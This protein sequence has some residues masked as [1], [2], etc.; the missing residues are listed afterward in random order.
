MNAVD[1]SLWKSLPGPQDITRVEL[2]NGIVILTR[3]NFNTPSVVLS[4]YLA[5]GSQF[6]PDEKLGLAHFT[7]LALMRGSQRRSFQEIYDALESV[8]ATLGFGASVHNTSFGGRALTEDLPLLLEL[9]DEC[10]RKPVFPAEQIEKL[11]AQLLTHLAIRAQDTGEMASLT[12]DQLVFDGH[13]YGR[14][15]E[16]YPDTVQAITREELVSFHQQQYGPK[17]MVIVI[18]GGIAA[19]QVVE[20]VRHTFSDWRNPQQQPTPHFTNPPPLKM[21]ERRHVPIPGKF[22]TDLVIGTLGP[23]RN[24]PDYMA[25][26][27]GNNILGQFGMMGRIGDVVRQQAG[28]AYYASASLNAWI[29]S[30]SWEVSAGVDPANLERAIEL[31]VGELSRFTAA[32]V[33]QDE[34]ENSQA[35]F[36]GRLPLSLESNS[37]VAGAL[38]NLERFHLGL[39]YLQRYPELVKAVT[40]AMVLETARRYLK[41]DRLAIVSAG[42]ASE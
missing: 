11:R 35:N 18:V 27:V 28:I 42:S 4:G 12:F 7:S 36:I 19:E 20:M 10:L 3:S 41:V 15:E 34:L 22:Q 29:D 1:P 16:G 26:S 24:S 23:K 30:G 25:A 8:G 9:L 14:P 17:Q 5:S 13:P 40:P 37:G 21:T 31:I 38:L 39:D 33:S 32:P 2:D 6:D